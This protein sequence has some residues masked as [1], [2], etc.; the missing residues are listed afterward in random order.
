MR[1][2]RL[3]MLHLLTYADELIAKQSTTTQELRLVDRTCKVWLLN[4]VNVDSVT[5]AK[6]TP[7]AACGKSSASD[8]RRLITTKPVEQDADIGTSKR[9]KGD[10]EPHISVQEAQKVDID[11]ILKIASESLP[12]YYDEIQLKCFMDYSREINVLVAKKEVKTIGFAVANYSREKTHI[13]SLAVSRLNRREGAAGRLI[14]HLKERGMPISLYML[15]SNIVARSFYKK[16]CF[17]EVE[18]VLD[19]YPGIFR[20][21]K[22][23]GPA[24][25]FMMEWSG[26]DACQQASE[27]HV[28]RA[29]E[30]WPDFDMDQQRD[31]P[32]WYVER[33][34]NKRIR[35]LETVRDLKI[36]GRQKSL[37]GNKTAENEFLD[38]ARAIE[39]SLKEICSHSS[40]NIQ[41]EAWAFMN[42][43][44]LQ[45][46][47][48]DNI[49]PH[50]RY[51]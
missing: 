51:D 50:T 18:L 41:A 10:K 31:F 45:R 30:R 33:L 6:S 12:I 23:I 13:M 26:K 2:S 36:L 42:S 28:D 9:A 22:A 29:D 38:K 20:N 48:P 49:T 17:K 14:D 16:H 19:Y 5:L 44:K 7:W 4:Y 15:P 37:R 46:D 34:N 43:T 21:N 40:G 47:P 8:A 32:L 27:E 24:D 25:A 3:F 11:D 39:N 35:L 1:G